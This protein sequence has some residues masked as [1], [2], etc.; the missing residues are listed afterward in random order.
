MGKRKKTWLS[1]TEA[2]EY[3][4]SVNVKCNRVTFVSKWIKMYD[5]GNKVGGRWIIVP[6]KLEK[7]AKKNFHVK[8][9]V[10]AKK[11]EK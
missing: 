7:F 1:V 2:L 5:L 9:I 6:G 3:L 4:K 11:K 8:K 10:N